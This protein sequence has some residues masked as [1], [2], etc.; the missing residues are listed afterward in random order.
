MVTTVLETIELHDALIENINI[1]FPAASVTIDIA[2]YPDADSRQRAKAKLVFENVESISQIADLARLRQ[3]AAAGN[4]NYWRPSEVVGG[5]TYIYLVD[6]CVVV[7][8][9]TVRMDPVKSGS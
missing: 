5:A 4:I 2:Y 3:N 7:T 1:D 6:G 9:K 8:A